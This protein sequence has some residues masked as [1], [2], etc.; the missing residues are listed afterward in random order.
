[1]GYFSFADIVETT[2][3]I[4]SVV[5]GLDDV[6]DGLCGDGDDGD[7][8][9][10]DGGDGCGCSCGD[11]GDGGGGDDGDGGEGGEGGDGCACSDAFPVDISSIWSK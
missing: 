11:G 4:E 5:K 8:G 10:G 2:D 9:D 1:M 7:V 6:V 3:C